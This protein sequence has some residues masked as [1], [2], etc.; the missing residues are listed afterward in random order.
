MLTQYANFHNE[1]PPALQQIG[2]ILSKATQNILV[3]GDINLFANE[4]KTNFVQPP[5]IQYEAYVWESPIQLDSNAPSSTVISPRSTVDLPPLEARVKKS[6]FLSKTYGLTEQDNSLSKEEKIEKLR[7]QYQ[8]VKGSLKSEFHSKRGLEQLV[9]FYG[10]EPVQQDKA[11]RE[12]EEQNNKISFLK[13]A[14]TKIR[15]QLLEL[16][17]TSVQD[18]PL[19]E[20]GPLLVT[21]PARPY[22]TARGLYDYSAT[23]DTELSFLEGDILTITE[24]DESGWWYA[25]LRGNVG[26]IPRNYVEISPA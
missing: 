3:E 24:Q 9:K 20:E 21:Q 7:E 18:D 22:V 17:D 8:E 6:E 23:N 13:D 5:E 26:F 15:S 1:I 10:P 16:G 14:R 11:K 19:E 12:L 2:Q 25:E 4:N